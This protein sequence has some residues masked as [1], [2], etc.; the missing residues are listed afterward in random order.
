MA[1]TRGI[2]SL[3][4][5]AMQED[6]CGGLL[7]AC[8]SP[9]DAHVVGIHIGIFCGGSTNPRLTVRE[10]CILQVLIAHLLEGLAAPRGAHAI[11]LD[12]DETEFGQRCHIPVVGIERLRCV[13]IAGTGVDILDD[14][15]F[16]RGVE[17]CGTLDDA[18]HGGGAIAAWGHED[19]RGLPAVSEDAGEIRGL[20]E[21]GSLTPTLS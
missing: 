21:S 9:E 7:S 20:Y 11:E 3:I 16:L 19:L 2:G 4:E 10:A 1:A 17:V 8:R 12:D 6:G 14:R 5:I 15:I 18:P 13:G